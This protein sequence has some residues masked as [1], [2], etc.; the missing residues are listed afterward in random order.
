MKISEAFPSSFLKA[1]DLG[2]KIVEV[3]LT[4]VN[5]EKVGEDFKLVCDL[6]GKNKKLVLNKTNA[7]MIAS[8]FG[9]ET[10]EWV[11]KIISLHS[12]KVAFQGK[13]VD[14]LRVGMAKNP[15]FMVEETRTNDNLWSEGPGN[16]EDIPF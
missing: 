6:Q 16:N 12:E 13:I 11:G 1:E 4:A 2:G 5:Y 3:K 7:L 10:D 14:A 8:A 15:D 9:D